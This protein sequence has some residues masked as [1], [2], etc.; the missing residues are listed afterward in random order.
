M[1]SSAPPTAR[2]L[3]ALLVLAVAVAG[4]SPLGSAPQEPVEQIVI[5]GVTPRFAVPECVPRTPDERTQQACRTITQVLRNDLRFERL[6]QFVPDSLLAAVPPLD[7]D[8][9][10][11]EDWQGIGA[12]ILVITR[13]SIANDE[14]TVE[15]RVYFVDS[16]QTMLARRYSGPAHNP[17]IFA[18]QA[19]DDIMTLTQY[20][21]VARTRI[22]F[23]SDRDS[24]AEK[25]SKELY[26]VDYDGFNPRRVTV[27]GSVNILPAWSPDGQ[28]LAYV[29]YRRVTPLVFLARIF[30]GKSVPNV[31][32]ERGNSQAFAPAFSPDGQKIAYASNR[33]G[34][35]DIWVANADGSGTQQLTTTRAADTAP[36]WSP[37]GQE[38][39]FTSSRTG[40]PQLYIMSNDGLNVRRLT[41]VGNYNDACAWSPARQFSEVAYTSRLQSGG[42]DIAVID[43][44]TRQVRQITRGRGSC[45]YPTWAPNGRHLAFS[46]EQ[47]ETWA[48]TI[49]DREGL[50]LKRLATGPGNNV[51]PDWGP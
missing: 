11:F 28:S 34:N 20:K 43:L 5:G 36:C 26:I 31:T 13:A 30:E 23:T 25:Q 4:G 2:A 49:A 32:A 18:H 14:L 51:Q 42:F 37:T 46:C 8:N 22:A 38:I 12:R 40:T 44:A 16:G 27:N 35:M 41:R 39:A 45:E 17:R 7:P 9:P 29:S 24:T 15:A 21:G 10:V 47:R 6:F 33:S 1:P 50:S 48:I 3:L 19:S